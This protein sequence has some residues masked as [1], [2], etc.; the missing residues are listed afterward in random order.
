MNP[1]V[2]KAGTDGF[3]DDEDTRLLVAAVRVPTAFADFYSRNADRVIAYF[4][5]RILCP[6]T[7]A[8]LCA[9]T[10]A[11]AYESRR[12]FAP[13]GGSAVAWLFGIAGNLYREWL[14]REVVIDRSRRR[15]GLVTPTLVDEDLERIESLVDLLPLREALQDAL[16]ALSPKLRDAV[17]LR[18]ALSWDYPDIAEE[19]GCSVGAARVRVSRGLDE[20]FEHMEGA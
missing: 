20:L 7:A 16:I 10:F 14:R 1:V 4:Y 8:E 11:Q 13:E 3:T 12:R 18:V 9:E 6:H 19:L 5:R 2:A 15:L 17:V